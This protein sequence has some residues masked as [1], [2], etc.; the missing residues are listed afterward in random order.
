MIC[1]EMSGIL[2]TAIVPVIQAALNLPV[3]SYGGSQVLVILGV[4]LAMEAGF[5]VGYL[6]YQ[7]FMGEAGAGAENFKY[8]APT[9]LSSGNDLF[10]SALSNAEYYG[11]GGPIKDAYNKVS[12]YKEY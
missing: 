11:T 5:Q 2:V 8:Q 12:D 6:I 7:K 4:I 9:L 1:F 3:Y 10:N